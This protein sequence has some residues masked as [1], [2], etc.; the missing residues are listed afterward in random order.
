MTAGLRRSLA[1]GA[2]VDHH[3]DEL[4]G[5]L[6]PRRRDVVGLFDR[7]RAVGVDGDSLGRFVDDHEQIDELLAQALTNRPRRGR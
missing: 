7:V 1:T 3:V 4:A 2:P 5:L 6:L